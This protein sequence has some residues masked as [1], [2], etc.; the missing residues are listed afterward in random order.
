[1]P[2]PLHHQ[3]PQ[4]DPKRIDPLI[5]I[6]PRRDLVTTANELHHADR[7]IDAPRPRSRLQPAKSAAIKPPSPAPCSREYGSDVTKRINSP[8]RYI[9]TAQQMVRYLPSHE[10]AIIPPSTG[11]RYIQKVKP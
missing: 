5:M 9:V 11:V 3:L 8:H 4:L 7:L 10:S 1:M 6:I 2:Q